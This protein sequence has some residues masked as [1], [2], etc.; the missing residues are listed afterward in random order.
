MNHVKHHN[1]P[2]SLMRRPDCLG[3]NGLLP[4][5]KVLYCDKCVFSSTQTED[6]ENHM[7]GHLTRFYCFYCNQVS[8]SKKEL[9]VHLLQHKYPFRCRYCGQ[10]YM[11]RAPLLNHI[12]RFHAKDVGPEV[13][14]AQTAAF[15]PGG[16]QRTNV[17]TVK[18]RIPVPVARNDHANKSRQ[19]HRTVDLNVPKVSPELISPVKNSVQHNMALTVPLPEEVSIPAG[20][21]VELIEVKTVNGTKEL[22]LRLVSQQEKKS[23]LDDTMLQHAASVNPLSSTL[24][25]RNL[26]NLEKAGKIS[27]N[28]KTHA[29]RSVN[30]EGPATFQTVVD[31]PDINAFCGGMFDPKRTLQESMIR[32]VEIPYALPTKVPR[33]TN[34]PSRQGMAG[35]TTQAETLKPPTDHPAPVITGKTV[36]KIP[37]AANQTSNG[38][39]PSCKTPQGENHLAVVRPRLPSKLQHNGGSV[40]D[41]QKEEFGRGFDDTDD[42]AEETRKHSDRSSVDKTNQ[43]GGLFISPEILHLVRVRDRLSQAV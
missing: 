27:V 35:P 31:K 6:F 41:V 30:V 1:V 25:H 37:S 40:L 14:N 29:A 8:Y 13:N 20:C 28:G 11:R 24:N 19:R 36:K 21:M 2:A 22:K 38:A 15:A 17:P 12:E 42:H 23:V 33:I 4:P 39:L 7:R 34:Y 43:D 3:L 16:V 5:Q 18:V 9:E 26:L 10:G 32:N